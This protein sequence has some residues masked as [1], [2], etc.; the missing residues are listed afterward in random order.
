MTRG[1]KTGK[2]KGQTNKHYTFEERKK[3]RKPHRFFKNKK[4]KEEKYNERKKE[5]LSLD[6]TLGNRML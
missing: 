1:T 5:R 2:N 4:N 3:K 6:R